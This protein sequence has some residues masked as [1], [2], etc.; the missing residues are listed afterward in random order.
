MKILAFI[1][2]IFLPGTFIAVFIQLLWYSKDS[3]NNMRC[4]I[5]RLCSLWTCLTGKAR[6][7]MA[8]QQCHL[9]SGSIGQQPFRS[10]Q[11]LSEAGRSGGILRSTG[12][13]YI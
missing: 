13:M 9:N 1:T 8:A 2:T 3:T 12:T 7:L 10:Q 4:N 6:R 11:S 5:Y